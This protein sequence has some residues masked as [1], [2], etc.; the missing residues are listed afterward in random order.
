MSIYYFVV[1]AQWSNF[2]GYFYLEKKDWKDELVVVEGEW[3]QDVTPSAEIPRTHCKS[4][5]P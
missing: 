3:Y 1:W 4:T 2:I 5:T